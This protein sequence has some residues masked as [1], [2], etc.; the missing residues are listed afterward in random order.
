MAV[1]LTGKVFVIKD[2]SLVKSIIHLK[3]HDFQL[4][5]EVD[6]V[7]T[8]LEA[9]GTLPHC[10]NAIHHGEVHSGVKSLKVTPLESDPQQYNVSCSCGNS[11]T[12]QDV[13]SPYIRVEAYK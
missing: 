9:N 7:I 8:R 5:A 1:N 13:N 2:L 10:L 4:E 11:W 12:M 3:R 6:G